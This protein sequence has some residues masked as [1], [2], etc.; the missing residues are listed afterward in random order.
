MSIC[1]VCYHPAMAFLVLLSKQ[2]HSLL[3]DVLRRDLAGG[4]KLPY[5]LLS[6]INCQC[7]LDQ[8]ICF[9]VCKNSHFRGHGGIRVALLQRTLCCQYTP[10]ELILKPALETDWEWRCVCPAQGLCH[11]SSSL[12]CQSQGPSHRLLQCCDPWLSPILSLLTRLGK[13]RLRSHLASLSA[14]LEV[15]L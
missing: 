11:H 12:I 13:F 7:V 1:T 5:K 14:V 2:S 15:E 10:Y 4:V 9:C 3:S 8:C 6:L